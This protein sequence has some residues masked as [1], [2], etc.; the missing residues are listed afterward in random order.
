MRGSEARGE[1][2]YVIVGAG[3]AGCTLACR[4]GADPDVRILVLEAGPPDRSLY[5]HMPATFARPLADDRYNWFYHSEPEPSLDGRRM[6]CPRGRVLGGSSSIN[7]MVYVRGHR[8]DYEGWAALGLPEWGFDQVLPW[9]VR[10]EGSDRQGVPWRG[11]EGPLRVSRASCT[12]PLYRAFIEAG[13][14]AGYPRSDDLNAPEREGFGPMDMTVWRGRRWSAARAYLRPAL[15]R[16]NVQVRTGALA[17][18][19]LFEGEGE[20]TRACGVQWLQGSARHEA[21]ARREVIL[22]GGAINSPQLL[23]LSGVGPPDALRAHG[24][25]VRAASPEVGRNLQDHLEVYVQHACREP[26]SLWGVDRL[27]RKLLVGL[28]W[29]LA[30]RGPAASNL[31]E[32]GAFTRTEPAVAHPDLQYHFFPMAVSYDGRDAWQGHG[33]QAHVGP[34][35]PESRGEV[36]LGSADPV[37]PP[38]ILFNYLQT[39]RDRREMRTAIRQAREVLAQRA[40]ER[41]RG[42]ELAPGADARSDAALDSFVRARVESAY[43]P[44]G[45]C[46]MGGPGEG[47]V[48]AEGRVHGLE[49]LRVVDASIMPLIPSG[50]LNAPTIM[51]AEKIAARLRG[52]E[53]PGG[54]GPQAGQ[55][56]G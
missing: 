54:R 43:H 14:E 20:G 55:E 27:P 45:T 12:N 17:T 36:R 29:L 11:T 18:R 47:V 38:R 42:A 35:R 48:D 31:F 50:N 8:L 39:E 23:M 30:G 6:Y 10:A 7:G 24:I 4:L 25:R 52:E 37:R 40:F 26:V 56:Q 9:F 22:S 1:Y 5:I 32:S 51:M 3:S 34:M 44:C 49:G 16:G 46:R 33:Y 53:A 13:M 2:D 41:F 19:I 15:A 28:E 21:R